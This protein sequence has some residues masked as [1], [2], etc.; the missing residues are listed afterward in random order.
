MTPTNHD[1]VPRRG[2]P[3]RVWLSLLLLALVTAAPLV[4]FFHATA[5]HDRDT[6]LRKKR[7][8]RVSLRPR[9]RPKKKKKTTEPV[10]LDGRV[11]DIREPEKE[12]KPKRPT[13]YLARFDNVTPKETKARNRNSKRKPQAGAPAPRRVSRVQS[14]TSKSLETSK[15]DA[16]QTT[17]EKVPT[18][19]QKKT[20]PTKGQTKPETQLM[21][22]NRTRALVP[23]LNERAAIANL[24]AL[25]GAA[26]S[27]DVLLD[28]DDGSETVLNT[29]RFQ[30]WDFFQTVKER[31]R[32]HWRPVSAYRRSDP[33]GK[34]YGVKDRLTVLSVTLSPEGELVS[35]LT[36]KNSGNPQLDEAAR[37]A[38]RRAAPF[39]NPPEGLV[40]NGSIRF[41][42]GFL[43]EIGTNRFKFFRM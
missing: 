28:V 42:F 5:T 33:T 2:T 37:I 19:A 14:K 43:F 3:Y 23:T 22:R 12:K 8:V 13:K 10:P 34:V 9:P 25:T 17:V 39:V 7:P 31:V 26:S 29:R 35:I 32:K 1:R 15:A 36:A 16:S 6:I 4:Y 11:V 21:K 41:R 20:D 18:K 24:Q 30:Y 27:D 38:F 40:R